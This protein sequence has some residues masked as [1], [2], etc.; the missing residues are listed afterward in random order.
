MGGHGFTRRA[1]LRGALAGAGSLLL[2]GCGAN[3]GS[4]TRGSGQCNSGGAKLSDIEHVVIFVQE[5]RSFD[6]YFGSYRGV[7]GF[8]DPGALLLPDGSGLNVFAQPGY[9][10]A[11]YDGHLL[12]F[13]LDT[14][15]NGECSHDVNHDWGPQHRSWNGGALDGFVREHL[16][17]EGVANGPLTMSYYQRADLQYYYALADAFTLCDRYHCSVIGPTDPNQ[18]Y[19]ISATLDPDGVAGGPKLHS[20]GS[21]LNGNLSW[22][23][24][25][26]QLLAHGIEF[27]A[28]TTPDNL[29]DSGNVRD[30]PFALFR[31]Y[32][33]NPDLISRA[34]LPVFPTDFLLDVATGRLPPVS[35]VYG[36]I[37]TSEHPPAPVEYGQ[38]TADLILKTLTSNPALWAKTALFITWD[39]NGGFFDHVPPPVPPPGTPGEFLT[40]A[41]LPATAENI[42]GPIGLGF[43]V[44]MLVVSPFSRGGFVCSDLFDHTSILRFLETRFGVEVPNLSAWR[45]SVT[46]DLTSAFNF[47]AP[48]ASVPALPGTSLADPRVLASTCPISPAGLIVGGVVPPYPVPPNSMP[49]QEPGSAP[50]P[51]GL[52]E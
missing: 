10:V 44:P 29:G 22:M 38:F 50:S 11:G 41:N 20:D 39:E 47:A 27:K 12:P 43:R 28:Y 25:P 36:S 1:L 40:M 14:T 34:V 9:D 23:T 15:K 49:M 37:V 33:S 19:L 8:G 24:M 2:P 17:I 18:V 5:N 51:S 35:W 45:R 16:K 6:H 32:R 21:V 48:D 42:R 26:E 31:Q 30:A 52:C 3:G 13:H 7:R 46:G 4:Q